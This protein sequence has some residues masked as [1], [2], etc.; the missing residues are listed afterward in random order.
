MSRRFLIHLCSCFTQVV[1]I[2][3]YWFSWTF[4]FFVS[5]NR[6]EV[7][8]IPYS[9]ITVNDKNETPKRLAVGQEKRPFLHRVVIKSWDFMDTMPWP[10]ITPR[11]SII[12]LTGHGI[13]LR[14]ND[15]KYTDFKLL[16]GCIFS[17]NGVLMVEKLERAYFFF[18]VIKAFSTGDRK[19]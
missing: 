18:S 9:I 3:F 11:L 13:P 2:V 16:T 4:G 19:A 15:P 1:V 12:F 5:M 7:Q 17:Y 6:V 10:K 14:K 8:W